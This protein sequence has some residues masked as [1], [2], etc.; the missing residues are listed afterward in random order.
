[1]AE[2]DWARLAVEAGASV[3]TGLSGLIV[4]AMRWG[5]RS[6]QRYQLMKDDYEEK[7]SK[8]STEARNNMVALERASDERMDLLVH[9]FKESFDG[10]RRQIDDH[11]LSTERDFMRKD[12]FKEFRDEYREDMRDLKTKIDNIGR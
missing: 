1:M 10:I 12:D 9:Q 3:A 4:G 6:S 7:I 8:A 2:T 5:R 11:K